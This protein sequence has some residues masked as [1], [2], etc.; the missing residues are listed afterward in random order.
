MPIKSVDHCKFCDSPS[1]V[2]FQAKERML[3]L[4]DEFTYQHC[5]DCGSLQL[6]TIPEDLSHYYPRDYYSFSPLVKS[7]PV[8]KLLKSAR[9]KLFLLGIDF[10][11]PVY[12]YWLKKLQPKFNQKIADL[13]CGNGQLIYELHAG[14][15]TDLHGFDPYVEKDSTLAENCFLW[16]KELSQ[17]DEKF[18]IIMMHHSFEHMAEPLQ[19]L[20]DCYAHLKRGGKMLIRTPV[21]DSEV[22]EKEKD[23]WVQ[24]DAPRHLLIPSLKGFEVIA[25][26]AGFRLNEV[27]FDSDAFQFLGTEIYKKGFSLSP[28][29]LENYFSTEEKKDYQKKALQYNEKG[30]G[31]QVCFY[32]EKEN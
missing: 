23:L 28:E 21:A 26:K 19:V 27:E 25:R 31:D 14:G 12:G 29:N 18:D 17:T 13:G 5:Q 8:K 2:E 24:L 15:F 9:M 22:F 3:G 4:G 11:S 20:N 6:K 30:L 1:F 7:A 16:K 10:L 32:L